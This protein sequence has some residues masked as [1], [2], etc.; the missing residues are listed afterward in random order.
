MKIVRTV[1]QAFEVCHKF[2]SLTSPQTAT[3][4]STITQEDDQVDD[5]EEDDED[6]EAED[7]DEEDARPDET[8]NAETKQ[9]TGKVGALI[10]NSDASFGCAAKKHFSRALANQQP[11]KSAI[12][13]V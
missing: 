3:S 12:A 13:C 2:S 9:S 1:G 8:S 11:S 10:I 5:D 7:E 6:D 4:E